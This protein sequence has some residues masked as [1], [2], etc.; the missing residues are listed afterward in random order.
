MRSVSGEVAMTSG[1]GAR[2][3]NVLSTNDVR[4]YGWLR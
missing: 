1:D 3:R 4:A 2:R